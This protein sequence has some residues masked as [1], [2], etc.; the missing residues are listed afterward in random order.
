MV[1]RLELSPTLHSQLIARCVARG[2]EFLSTPF[3]AES[4]ALLQ[5]LGLHRLKVPSGEITNGPLLVRLAASGLPLI[6]S[7]G[8]ADLAEVQAAL[9]LL[10]YA[11]V[12]REAVPEARCHAGFADRAEGRAALAERVTP[13]H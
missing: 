11:M 2:I 6:V 1:R 13:L 12:H 9:D 4:L 3:D 7:T 8:I 10:A 5:D